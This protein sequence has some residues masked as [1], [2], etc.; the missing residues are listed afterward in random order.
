MAKILFAWE[1]GGDYGHLARL[2]PL[3][4]ELLARGHRPIFVLRDLLGAE[5]I[6]APHGLAASR[7]VEFPVEVIVF[8]L[9]L[10]SE[11]GRE[12]RDSVDAGRCLS[13]GKFCDGRQDIPEG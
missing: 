7:L 4:R 8:L 11:H 2:L 13:S 5:A 9:S 12:E 1:L 6:L 10:F 3:A